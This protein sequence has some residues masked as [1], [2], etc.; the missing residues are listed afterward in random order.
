M[1][2]VYTETALEEIEA[3]LSHIANDNLSA[4]H[5]ASASF[6]STMDRIR[7]FPRTAVEID[8]PGAMVTPILPYRYL[9]FFTVAEDAIIIRNVRHSARRRPDF[10][11]DS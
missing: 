9:V 8:V 4:A 6:L 2:V 11:S 5:R 1:R 10:L 3:I 7:E